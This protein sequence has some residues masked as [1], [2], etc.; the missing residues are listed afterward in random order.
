MGKSNFIKNLKVGFKAIIGSIIYSI[1]IGI[2]SFFATMIF[3][4]LATISIGL[5]LLFA[6]IALLMG[7]VILGWIYRLLWKWK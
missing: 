4:T 1:A 2:L 5:M 7:V 6:I 3:G